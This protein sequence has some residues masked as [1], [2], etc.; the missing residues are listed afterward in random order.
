MNIAGSRVLVTGAGGF[1]GSHLT[2]TLVR[3]G[4]AVRAFVH[5]HARGD[6]GHL[7]TIDPAVAER[8]EVVA[9]DI[10]DR[11]AVCAA[12]RGCDLVFHLAALIGIPYSY[13]AAESYVDTNVRG[14]LNVLTACQD[15]GVARLVHTSTSEVYG[16]A[17]YTPIDERHPL[18]AQSPYAATK[19]AADQLALSYHA[20]F[21]TPVIVVRPFNTFG[22]RQS[23]RAVIP[24]IISQALAGDDIHLGSVDAVRDFLFVADTAQGFLAAAESDAGVGDVFNLGTGR[25]ETIGRVVELVGAQLGR[26]LRVVPQAE[27]QRPRGSEVWRL[28]CSAQKAAAQ[29]AWRPRYSLEAGIAATIQWLRASPPTARAARYAI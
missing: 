24:T 14:T 4:A 19:I 15:A 1:I 9:G 17:Q 25:G 21:G 23:T 16:T 22:P 10:R 12:V 20:A 2:E 28:E 3:S 7:E 6:W 11:S 27:R 18:Q 26:P 13:Q 8:L 5:Y 29:L